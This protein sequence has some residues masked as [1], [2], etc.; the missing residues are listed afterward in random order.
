MRAGSPPSLLR[1]T[2]SSTK[3]NRNFHQGLQTPIRY[4]SL[5]GSHH[6]ITPG[7]NLMPGGKG[8][9]GGGGLKFGLGEQGLPSRALGGPGGCKLPF[10]TL[11]QPGAL[12]PNLPQP[13]ALSSGVSRTACMAFH[14]ASPIWPTLGV[15]I[16]S[17][18]GLRTDKGLGN[19]TICL[20]N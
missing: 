7:G 19:Q 13:G 3:K 5:K 2:R 16:G 8:G 1:A 18:N 12:L 4:L 9:G 15:H 14:K 20:Y 17:T 10:A 11:P 6:T